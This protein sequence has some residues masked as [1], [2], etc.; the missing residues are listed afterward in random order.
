MSERTISHRIGYHRGN[1][2]TIVD[3]FGR[4]MNLLPSIVASYSVSSDF[5]LDKADLKLHQD[6]HRILGMHFRGKIGEER[7]AEG[8]YCLVRER[9]ATIVQPNEWES[10]TEAGEALVMCMLIERVVA[11]L[12]SANKACP[13]CGRTRLGMMKEG[14]FLIW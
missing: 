4:E 1:G 14:A 8:R 13:K 9:D 5:S 7:V 10:A 12:D 11:G 2:V 6:V 3:A